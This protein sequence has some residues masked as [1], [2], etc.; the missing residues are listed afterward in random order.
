MSAA[1]PAVRPRLPT[2][3]LV[4]HL[5]RYRR[6]VYAI[7]SSAHIAVFALRIVPGLFERAIFDTISGAA[8]AT[9]DVWTLIA[10]YVSTEL[11]RLALSFVD[12]AGDVTFR[13]RTAEL[14][15]HN[16]LASVL[17]RRADRPLPASPGEAINRLSHDVDE[18]CDFPLWL[19][20][21]AGVVL[22]ALLAIGIM[23]SINW[24]ITLFAVLPL[25]AAMV[26]SRLAWGR[27]LI[28][29]RAA[30]VAAGFATSLLGELLAAV[31][32]VKVAAAEDSVIARYAAL[33]ERRAASALREQLFRGLLAQVEQASVSLGIG[34]M[35][36]LAGQAMAAGEFTVGDFA[37][38]VYYMWFATE[39]PNVL[40]TFVGDYRTQEVSIER[41]LELVRPEPPAVLVATAE[42]AR[43]PE[44]AEATGPLAVLELRGASF[45]YPPRAARD[46]GAAPEGGAIPGGAIP[47]GAIP[48]VRPAGGVRG[49]DL[50]LACGSFTVV[51]GR[52]GSG[53]TTLL[54]LIMGLLPREEGEILWN[55][56][57]LENPAAVLRPPRCAYTPQV[58][59]LFSQP[60]R[61]NI[62]L[63]TPDT[64]ERL[65]AAVHQA[66]LEADVAQLERGL[67]TVV[68]PRGVRLSGG[69]VQRAAAARMFACAP[70]LLLVDDLSSALDVET[71][72]EL[73]AR[74]LAREGVTC[75]AV[76]HRRAALRRADQIVVL[77]DGGVAGVGT[78][79]ELLA[80]CEEMRR[81]WYGEVRA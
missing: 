58:P 26:L 48:D 43:S 33:C 63:G 65:P 54:R 4:L 24:R 37:L 75:L 41:L 81:L 39:L 3:T 27:L 80:S 10:L 17:R 13:Y 60:L 1:P 70:E 31:Q 47:G 11:A 79:D 6:W 18:V 56:V 35:L 8:P 12:V 61:D 32:A 68:G 30:R 62:L 2:W 42:P 46:D 76:S 57:A 25:A 20:E 59:R 52:V 55:G 66:V 73:W 14:L 5:V 40:G 50:R 38:F 19:P 53:K 74:L 71:E 7:H 28:Y 77:A 45:R 72:R 16:V 21:V 9:L 15:R 51:T 69:Q 64:P 67:D 34:L 44:P 22:T 36:V 49:V 29:R 23:A 78:L